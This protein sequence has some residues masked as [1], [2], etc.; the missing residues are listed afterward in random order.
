MEFFYIAGAIMMAALALKI[1][2]VIYKN[3]IREKK[4]KNDINLNL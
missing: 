3:L 4:T 1:G 2:Y